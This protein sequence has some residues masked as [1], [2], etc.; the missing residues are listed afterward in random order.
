DD[1]PF[2][3]VDPQLDR[4]RFFAP[5]VDPF[6]HRAGVQPDRLADRLRIGPVEPRAALARDDPPI[7]VLYPIPSV[8]TPGKGLDC[9]PR[10]L[11][12]RDVGRAVRSIRL[13]ERRW[14]RDGGTRGK[15]QQHGEGSSSHVTPPGVGGVVWAVWRGYHGEG[16]LVKSVQ[17]NASGLPRF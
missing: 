6:R 5:E 7:T 8:L 12:P 17:G 4:V 10:T 2:D 9:H 15:D 3:R 11:Q 1:V 16:A 14:R 13:C